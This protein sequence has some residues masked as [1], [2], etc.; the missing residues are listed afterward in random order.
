MV[1]ELAIGFLSNFLYDAAKKIKSEIPSTVDIYSESIDQLT[2]KYIKLEA[3]HIE[4]FLSEDS[5]QKAISDYLKNPDYNKILITLKKAFFISLDNEYFSEE[6][7]ESILIDF[8]KILDAKI[9]NDPTLREYI[10]LPYLKKIDRKMDDLG[11]K[12]DE[13]TD[14]IIR[15]IKNGNNDNIGKNSDFGIKKEHT[16]LL[17]ISR[18]QNKIEFDAISSKYIEELFVPRKKY[19][20]NFQQFQANLFS[21]RKYNNS[22]PLENQK[23]ENFNKEI[24]AKNQETMKK[25]PDTSKQELLANGKLIREN[26]ILKPKPIKNCFFLMGQAGIGKTNQLCYLAQKYESEYPII[27][28]NGIR[29]ILSNDKDIEQLVTDNFN[30]I[31][32]TKFEN[33]LGSMEKICSQEDKSILFFIDAINECLNLELMRVYLGNLLTNNK[34]KK[35]EFIVSCRDID[36]RFFENEEA[37]SENI[38][39]VENPNIDLLNDE[40]FAKAWRRYKAYFKLEGDVSEEIVNICKQPIMLR[41][42]SEAYQGGK[43]PEQD[44]K[45]IEI[46]NKYW[47]KKLGGTGEKRAAQKFLFNIVNEMVNQ[48]RAELIETEIEE[49]TKQTTDEPQT[50]F[51]KVLSEN[52]IL[53]K[54]FDSRTKEHKIGF[55]YEAFFEY[56]IARYFLNKYGTLDDKNLIVQ[57]K[58]IIDS[59]YDFRNLMGAIEYI[60]LLLEDNEEKNAD[61]KVYVKMLELLSNYEDKNLRQVTITIIKK[62]RSIIGIEKSLKA[63]ASDKNSEINK[64]TYEIFQSNYEMFDVDFQRDI[65]CILSTETSNEFLLRPLNFILNSYNDLPV[66][67]Q[68][69]LIYFSCCDFINTKRKLSQLILSQKKIPASVYETIVVNLVKESDTTV[70]HNILESLSVNISLL[71]EEKLKFTLKQLIEDENI[72]HSKLGKLIQNNPKSIPNN[73]TIDFV[74]WSLDH[75][76]YLVKLTIIFLIKDFIENKWISVDHK[77]SNI[78]NKL[79]DDLD[80]DVSQKAG[81]YLLQFLKY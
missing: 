65:L 17:D 32:N 24:R 76:D 45:R 56:I 14:R 4:I 67:I 28:L 20:E 8:F 5:V 75:C 33:V 59:V 79:I 50:T 77:Y 81:E 44:I 36:W 1:V 31:S 80:D 55:T 3:S 15:T 63:L 40:E 73:I 51:S 42:F 53:Y 41:F 47:D 68:K 48:K 58:G 26:P 66:K 60:I 9:E 18:K 30:K 78:I 71:D 7:S 69:L 37:I 62:L 11:T 52:I 39:H 6:E 25:Y 2:D 61:E 22:L 49:L 64:S 74:E 16:K 54:D 35:I 13:N 29:I 46:F 12:N 27:F 10:Q 19:D 70:R 34:E 38:F 23:N 72:D 43:V 57:F 21:T